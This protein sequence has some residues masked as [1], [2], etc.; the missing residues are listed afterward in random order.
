MAATPTEREM[1]ALLAQWNDWLAARTDAMLS[2]ED[3]VRG[4]GSDADRADLAAAFVARKVVGD[5][6]QEITD[7]AEHDRAQGRRAGQPSRWSTTSAVLSAR[8]S[9]T[10]QSLSMRSCGESRRT[11]RASKTARLPKSGWRLA[12]TQI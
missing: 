11:C 4:S 10:Q 6:L 2:L 8:T 1:A 3:R 12:P 9:K 5:R 7:L